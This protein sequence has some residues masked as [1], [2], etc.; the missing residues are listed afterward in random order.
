MK[1][2]AIKWLAGW[3]FFPVFP[4]RKCQRRAKINPR[5]CV[6]I[7]YS[8]S[9][10]MLPSLPPSSP[11]KH[12]SSVDRRL[13][14]ASDLLTLALQQNHSKTQRQTS[15]QQCMSVWW[16]TWVSTEWVSVLSSNTSSFVCVFWYYGLCLIT[17]A[18][19]CLYAVRESVDVC[20][21][22]T[23]ITNLQCVCD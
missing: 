19:L 22:F 16:C 7:C 1:I 17:A 20:R 2:F 13:S 18:V 4:I 8:V 6:S 9:F 14:A 3:N 23:S 15:D 11:S 21:G 10:Q 12:H 5:C